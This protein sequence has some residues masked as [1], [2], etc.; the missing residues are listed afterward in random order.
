MALEDEMVEL[1]A[2]VLALSEKRRAQLTPHSPLLG[3]IPELDSMAV[4][5][6]LHAIEV[7]YEVT[8]DDEAITSE[9]FASIQTLA[10]WVAELRAART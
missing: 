6:L 8:I 3:A 1:V 5:D 9:R 2:T 10:A 7:Q 4:L